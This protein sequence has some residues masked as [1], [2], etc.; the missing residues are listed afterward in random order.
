MDATQPFRCC[1]SCQVLATTPDDCS[2]CT[3]VADVPLVT[4]RWNWRQNNAPNIQLFGVLT[5]M[6]QVTASSLSANVPVI[7][8]ANFHSEAMTLRLRPSYRTSGGL[9]R[10]SQSKIGKAE[11]KTRKSGNQTPEKWNQK[12]ATVKTKSRKSRNQQVGNVEIKSRRSRK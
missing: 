6:T 12:L 3:R 2:R 5:P 7:L 11:I 1:F 8:A 9:G 10:P 4:T